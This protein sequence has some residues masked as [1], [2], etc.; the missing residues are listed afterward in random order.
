MKEIIL[1][2]AEEPSGLL[3]RMMDAVL[4]NQSYHIVKSRENL[5]D[6]RNKKIL[7]AV[8]LNEIGVSNS[9]NQIFLELYKRGK[10][11]L[12]GS[13]AAL[14]IHSKY[15]LFTKT[16]AQ[17]IIFLANSLGC[18]FSGRPL[19]EAS[20]NLENFKTMEKVYKLP[21]EDICLLQ[22]RELRDRFLGNI[23]RTKDNP[24][25]LLVLHSSSRDLS[26]T[27]TLWDMVKAHLTNMEITEINVG[28]GHIQDCKGCP[29]RT[30]KHFGEENKCFYGG[31]LVEE[32]YPAIMEADSLLLICPNYNDMITAPLVATINRLTAL[33]RQRKFYD[34]SIFSII[35]SGYSGGE[36]LANQLI[37]SLNINKTFRLPPYFSLMAIANDHGAIN[38]VPDIKNKAKDFALSIMKSI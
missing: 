9:L 24:K 1:I 13:Q 36:A 30:C 16:S 22:C 25:K 29:Y 6:L 3:K 11:S 14:L 7:F 31:V 23:I 21:L 35:V 5:P 8:E 33:Y 37:S 19:V 26:N 17:S 10:D 15:E 20:S 18:S 34:K 12:L 38:Q 2:M 32:V 4:A 28:K 27:L